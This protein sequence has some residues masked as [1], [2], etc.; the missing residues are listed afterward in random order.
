MFTNVG[1]DNLISTHGLSC[2]QVHQSNWPC[3]A[4]QNGF[5]QR[6]SSSAASMYSHRKR[7]H[8]STFFQAHIVWQLEAKVRILGVVPAKVSMVRRS[9][10]KLHFQTQI[11]SA[12]FAVVAKSTGD[13]RLNSNTVSNLQMLDVFA[14][15]TKNK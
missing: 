15:P 8:Q 5:S 13:P 2:K 1:D 6:H 12:L 4:N 14:A 7:L 3:P 10:A 9:S 11:V